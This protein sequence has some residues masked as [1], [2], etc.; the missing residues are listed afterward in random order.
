MTLSKIL[1]TMMP[2]TTALVLAAAPI[3]AAPCP[4]DQAVYALE[5]DNTRIVYT[6][7]K[8]EFENDRKKRVKF[9]ALREDKPLW[10]VGGEIYCDDILGLCTLRLD[11]P[12][13][14]NKNL[15]ATTENCSKFMV[16]VTEIQK[17]PS[18]DE[19]IYIAFGGLPQFSIACR[20]IID[21]QVLDQ[22]NFTQLE[23]EQGI[24]LP[25]YVRFSSCGH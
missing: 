24:F 22:Q 20:E 1:K 18:S 3:N 19:I 8:A 14:E 16:A 7:E 4:S 9:E 10:S 11:A 2:L 21:L 5:F 23:N 13:S 6:R 17:D 12:R 25:P 15:T